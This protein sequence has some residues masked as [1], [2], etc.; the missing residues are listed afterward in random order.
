MRDYE[1][2]KA[3]IRFLDEGREQQPS[4]DELALAAGLSPFHLHRLFS[5]WA[6]ITPKAFL[7]CLTVRHAIELLRAGESVLSTSFEVGLSG[8]GRLHDLCVS[9]ESASPGEIKAGGTGWIINA[10]FAESPFGLCLIAESPRGICHLSFDVDEDRTQAA[11]LLRHDWPAAKLRW[12]DST[13]CEIAA[14]LFVSPE[15]RRSDARLKAYVRGTDFQIRVWRALLTLPP[16]YLTSYGKIAN[17]IGSPT[18]ARAVGTAIGQ[19]QLAVLIPCHRVIR[20][21]GVIGEYRWGAE[22]KKAMLAWET[23]EH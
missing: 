16:G 21:T 6:G 7:K 22:R 1:R 8:L 20:E 15:G 12:D 14:T 11:E 23:A 10:G 5:D 9:L 4:L 13:A 3:I 17:A 18:A 19:N 2:V